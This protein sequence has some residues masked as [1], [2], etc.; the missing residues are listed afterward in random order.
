MFSSIVTPEVILFRTDFT[1][2]DM[3]TPGDVTSTDISINSYLCVFFHRRW[4]SASLNIRSKKY[5]S[6]KSSIFTVHLHHTLWTVQGRQSAGCTCI[7]S[8]Q[9]WF[10]FHSV[11]FLLVMSNIL[12]ND[13]DALPSNREYFTAAELVW[14]RTRHIEISPEVTCAMNQLNAYNFFYI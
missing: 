14:L 10:V 8:V 12:V 2:V 11:Q 7:T 3:R 1:Q 5:L 9:H 4:T 13:T 6:W